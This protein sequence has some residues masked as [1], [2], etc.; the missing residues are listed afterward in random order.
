MK[1][2]KNAWFAGD[3][4]DRPGLYTCLSQLW[5]KRGL[6]RKDSSEQRGANNPD[7]CNSVYG[8]EGT[9]HQGSEREKR[10]KTE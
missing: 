2:S 8:N 3:M 7:R 9:S 10:G 4:H 6:Q 5:K 1:R